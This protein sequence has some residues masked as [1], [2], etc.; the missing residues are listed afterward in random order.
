[1][2][3]TAAIDAG[4]QPAGSQPVTGQSVFWVLVTLATATMSQPPPSSHRISKEMGSIDLLRSIPGV[5]LFDGIVDS[6]MLWKALLMFCLAVFPQATKVFAMRGIPVSQVCAAVFF[7]ATT[8][9][10]ITELGGFEVHVWRSGNDAKAAGN[11]YSPHVFLVAFV[12]QLVLFVW[13]C[14]NLPVDSSPSLV[15]ARVIET[16][17]LLYLLVVGLSCAQYI[18]CRPRRRQRNV[19]RKIEPPAEENLPGFWPWF[20]V[21]AMFQTAVNKRPYDAISRYNIGVQRCLSIVG[22]SIAIVRVMGGI[23]Y[24]ISLGRDRVGLN[25]DDDYATTSPQDAGAQMPEQQETGGGPSKR[26]PFSWDTIHNAVLDQLHRLC[27]QVFR[28]LRQQDRFFKVRGWD[29]VLTLVV[30]NLV[31]TVLY[32]LVFFDQDGT[33][34]PGR[35][36]YLG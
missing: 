35:T 34:T 8:I 7:F 14:C 25:K 21:S 4:T 1:M 28:A 13:V 10:L 31:I 33:W 5:C 11:H 17:S 22:V 32:Y 24:L 12:S 26:V 23:G 19:L 36:S 29:L 2:N 15:A 16:L 3:S 27:I 30:M 9:R 18:V 20:V 6:I